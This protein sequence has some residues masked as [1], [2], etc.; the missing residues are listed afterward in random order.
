MTKITVNLPDEVLPEP[1]SDTV[2]FGAEPNEFEE[3]MVEALE[4][5]NGIAIPCEKGYSQAAKLR[6]DFYHE[7]NRHRKLNVYLYDK[8]TFR[9]VGK[10]TGTELHILKSVMPENVRKL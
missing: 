10:G 4:S 2:A 7:R 5:E 9:I 8:L 3:R 1:S 6:F